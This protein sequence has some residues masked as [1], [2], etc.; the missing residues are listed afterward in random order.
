M[1]PFGSIEQK[2][3][4]DDPGCEPPVEAEAQEP[5]EPGRKGYR[6]HPVGVALPVV[7]GAI[8]ALS[9]F[10]PLDE[11]NSS[12][13]RIQKNT[14]IQHGGWDLIALG[15]IIALYALVGRRRVLGVVLLSL[16]AG[17][18]VVKYASDKSLR[19]LSPV[20]AS[21]GTREEKVPFGVAIYVA[22]AGAVL[23]F[24]GGWVMLNTRTLATPDVEEP[25]RRCPECAE[26]ILAAAR[27]CKHCGARLDGAEPP[28]PHPPA[29]A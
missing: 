5:R 10:L 20:G 11:S 22:G 25:T 28:A 9:V 16:V 3:G 14:L 23:A 1:R 17:G 12:F 19:T 24:I 7:G 29:R 26:T 4:V 8:L 2:R 13:G 27:M 18:F 15:A 21:E 6:Y